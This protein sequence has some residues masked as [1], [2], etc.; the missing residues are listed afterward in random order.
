MGRNENKSSDELVC[1]FSVK[2]KR[3]SLG[4]TVIRC[5]LEIHE[6]QKVPNTSLDFKEQG[7]VS[8]EGFSAE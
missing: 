3:P 6:V 4:L 1:S 7:V 5:G 2:Q 8:E